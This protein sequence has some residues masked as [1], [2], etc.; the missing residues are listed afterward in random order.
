[1][2]ILTSNIGSQY[3]LEGITG[4]GEIKQGA[5]DSVMRDLR[6]HFR[7]EFLNRIDELVLFKPLQ[8][9]EIE[10]IVDLQLEHVRGRLADRKVRLDVTEAAREYIAKAGYDPVYGAR[11][12]KRYI[13]R[14]LET[15]IG[16]ALLADE[17]GEGSAVQVDVID[18]EL[19]VIT[20]Q[21]AEPAGAETGSDVVH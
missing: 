18:G 5:R 19:S 1:V 20:S 8:L 15:K 14:E 3:L 2:I 10:R 16:R 21:E 11:P 7:P 6:N 17:L 9:Q 13:Q 12:L 4:E